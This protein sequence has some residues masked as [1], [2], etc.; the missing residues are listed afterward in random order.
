MRDDLSRLPRQHLEQIE[1]G[2]RE[3]NLLAT[4]KDEVPSHVNRH[5]TGREELRFLRPCPAQDD[6][7]ASESS[8]MPKGFVR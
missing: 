6:S 1:L 2:W 5:V 3:V 8:A 4:T 7:E